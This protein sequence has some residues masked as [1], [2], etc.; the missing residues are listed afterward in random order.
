ML[1]G[2]K[3]IAPLSEVVTLR[4]EAVMDSGPEFN[5]MDPE[6]DW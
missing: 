1:S 5:G 3:Y 4:I 6:E 2:E